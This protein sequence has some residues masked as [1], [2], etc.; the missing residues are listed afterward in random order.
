MD[1]QDGWRLYRVLTGD[2]PI[3]KL[4]GGEEGG[5]SAE[6][7]GR[8]VREAEERREVEKQRKEKNRG[9]RNGRGR[10]MTE[11]TELDML[12]DQIEKE[13]EGEVVGMERGEHE[14]G[15]SHLLAKAETGGKVPT[16]VKYAMS[17][18]DVGYRLLQKQGWQHGTALGKEDSE[19]V[20][21]TSSA[22][23][24]GRARHFP[25]AATIKQDRLGLGVNKKRKVRVGDREAV[26]GVHPERK[27]GRRVETSTPLTKKQ[28]ETAERREAQKRRSLLAYMNT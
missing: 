26:D 4:C 14:T 15:L 10:R 13:D 2:R 18:K 19:T 11:Q 7:Y 20:L 25:I 17:E 24:A 5:D 8:A 27:V 12:L 3:E 16:V 23:I 21:E 1:G 6:F 22:G 28:R 9:G